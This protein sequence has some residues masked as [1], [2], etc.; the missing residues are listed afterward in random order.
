MRVPHFIAVICLAIVSA[1]A[2]MNFGNAQQ[3]EGLSDIQRDEINQMIRQ[4]ILNNPEIIPEAVEVLRAR[5]NAAA[6]MRSE[7]LLYND[8]YSY[9]AGNEDGDITI[10]EFYDYNCGFC[11]QVP[12]I[13]SR[14]VEEDKNL[15]VIFKELPI[16]AESSEMA[17]MAAMAAMKQG[18][19]IEFHNAMMK[20]NRA[21]N[22][23]LILKVASDVGL[24][25]ETLLED[26]DDPKIAANIQMT[27][28]LV[29]NIGISGTPGFIIGDQIIAGFKPYDELK[30]II[31]EQREARTM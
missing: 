26:M 22:Q 15:R 18:K 24:D 4:Y 17:S 14:L 2:Y 29:R 27:L 28:A 25:H 5:Q 21:I 19:F 1:V 10:V 23:E 8:G 7:D 6:I 13:L 11:K 20:N 16:L 30:R 9:V 3:E 12:G 31:A